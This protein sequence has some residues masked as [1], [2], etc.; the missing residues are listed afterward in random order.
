MYNIGAMNDTTTQS[1]TQIN[2]EEHLGLVYK[3]A[4]KYALHY[5]NPGEFMHDEMFE[6]FR[7]IG[8][9]GLM[10]AI[11]SY[12]ES[13]GF[14]FSTHANFYIV[15][16]ITEYFRK[17]NTQKRNYKMLTYLDDS[18]GGKSADGDDKGLAYRDLIP[19]ESSP[20]P[21]E[22]MAR[23]EIAEIVRQKV[24]TLGERQKKVVK[25]YMGI[26]GPEMTFDE[27]SK[28]M[29]FSRQYAKQVYDKAIRV[30]RLRIARA[31]REGS[32][33]RR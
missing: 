17:M 15:G 32:A 33:V 27:I 1:K 21:E 24:D 31:E 30:L 2:A 10:K 7:Q 12:D 13:K 23:S 14:A 4:H 25:M 19:D 11:D 18:V 29:G 16:E 28:A 8:A 9:I 20:N 22:E 3:V 6:E 26:D 5:G